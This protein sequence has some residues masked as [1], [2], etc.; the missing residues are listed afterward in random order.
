MPASEAGAGHGGGNVTSIWERLDREEKRVAIIHAIHYLDATQSQRAS[1][2][3]S[4]SVLSHTVCDGTNGERLVV[5]VEILWLV[6]GCAFVHEECPLQETPHTVRA[7]DF[8]KQRDA[9]RRQI[10]SGWYVWFLRLLKEESVDA[11]ACLMNMS[12]FCLCSALKLSSKY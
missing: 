9:Q 4:S 5:G 11:A 3:V 2:G 6:N 1:V 8:A 10:C 7:W 12:P